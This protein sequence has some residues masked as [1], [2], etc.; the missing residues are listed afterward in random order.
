MTL[1]RGV[2]LFGARL[3]RP[4]I[5]AARIDIAVDEFDY[6][7]GRRVAV[8]IARLEHA[9]VT[10]VARRITR[11]KHVEQL[12]HH[13]RIAQ[14]CGCLTARMEVAALCERD[15][16][17]DDRAQVLRLGKRRDDLLVLDQRGGEM[18][19]QRGALVGAPIELAV[20][21]A[22]THRVLLKPPNADR[23]RAASASLSNDP[24]SAWPALRCS[25]AAS[26]ALPC[27]DADPSAPALP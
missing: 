19:E 23:P 15:Q 16:L 3:D 12:L 26:Q 2:R 27:R 14:L 5:L 7:D 20:C 6:A 1:R 10:A 8:A 21:I 13:W 18:L 11:A 4:R 22:V 9:G 25:P 24:R 17:L